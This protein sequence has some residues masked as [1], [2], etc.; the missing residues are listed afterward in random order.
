VQVA[1][2]LPDT[3]AAVALCGGSGSELAEIAQKSGADVY[4][5]AEIKHNIGRWAEESG[6]C[7]I[8]G[9]HYA[10]EKPAVRLLAQHLKKYCRDQNWDLQIMES[11]MEKHPFTTVDNN[12]F[13]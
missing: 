8:D 4:I 3:I 9:T 2:E 12:S 13:R 1:G 10:T 7:I 5:S 6:F 11:K